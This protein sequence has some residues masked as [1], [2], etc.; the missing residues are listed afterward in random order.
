MPLHEYLLGVGQKAAEAAAKKSADAEM[1]RRRKAERAAMP[2]ES[3]PNGIDNVLRSFRMHD[4]PEAAFLEHH[5][6]AVKALRDS[7]APVNYGSVFRES[8]RQT[9]EHGPPPPY[10]IWKDT[11]IH[12]ARISAV[13]R[14]RMLQMLDEMYP[15]S[16]TDAE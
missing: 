5:A 7:G 12:H 3:S 14:L 11:P 2:A 1:A 13:R 10:D 15:D 8:R 4:I 16:R 6:A 9:L